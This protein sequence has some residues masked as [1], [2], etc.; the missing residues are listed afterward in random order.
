MD[1][2]LPE[3]IASLKRSP[4]LVIEA[5]P[6]A[7]KTTRVP[8][9][10]L[11]IVSG[12]V[13]VLEPRRIA[14]RLAARRVAWEIGEPVGQTIG[15]QVRFEEAVSSRTRVRFVTEGV[16]TR[17]LLSDR[18]LKGV[19]AVVLDE[20]HERHLESDLALALL[21]RL[22]QTRTDLRIIVM[23]A[24][25]DTSHVAEYLGGCPVLRSEGRLFEV[26]IRH[27]PYS[28]KSLEAQLTD[29]LELLI[30]E[31]PSG[32]VLAFLTGAAEIR[33]AMRE[34]QEVARRANL[35]VLPL[36]GDLSPAE[37][38]RAIMPAEQRKVIL[39][40]N[41]AESS[42]TVEGVNAV[43]D[44]G[45]ARIAT[46]SQ[47][48][49]LP[50]L[51]V[52]RVS[53]ASATQRAG[54]AGRTAPGRVLRL[55]GIEDYQRR[56]EHDAPEITRS[57]L[58]QL[59]LALRAMRI[60]DLAWLDAPPEA[61]W[62]IAEALLD[63]LG[64]SAER[65]LQLARYPLHPR[66]SRILI[67]AMERGVGED[68][69]V[70]A[71]LL[72]SGARAEKND[73]LTAID[74]DQDY[75]NQDYRT[76]QQV[77]LLRRIARPARQTEHNDDALLMSVLAGFPD[78]VAR[79]RAGNQVLLSTGGS[80]E[81][82]GDPPRY[83]FM[84]AV[85][86]EDRKDKPLPLIRMTAR[87]EPEWLIELFPDQV[88]E[89]SGVE[90]NRLGERVEAVSALLYDELVI[91]ESRGAAPDAEAAAGLLAQKALEAGIDRFVDREAVDEFVARVQF[92]GFE[93]PD[94]PQALK[95]L[96]QGL[97]SFN[98]LKNAATNLVSLLEQKMVARRL[99]QIAPERVR[100]PNGRQTKVHYE[101]GKP[102]W[103]ASRLQD[104][105]GMRETPRIGPGQT[106]VVVHLL[107]PNQRAVQTTSDLAGFWERLY[108]QVRRELMR[109]YPR[110]S[111]P[112]RP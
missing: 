108:P 39:A 87:I 55:Y 76:R 7:G 61:A 74:A 93:P 88:R 10:L 67:A 106:P 90:W 19:G 111:W 78:R 68:G 2:I 94:I 103:I 46:Y 100:L 62:E 51:H 95:D 14:A 17:R 21:K 18:T 59:C 96:C 54:R 1:A 110:H 71:A 28:A 38:D 91:Q 3:M 79:R 69:C 107:A 35:L 32:D 73:L 37:Q 104:F 4:N 22:Q 45:L 64:A 41:V 84:V 58:S 24:T 75:R 13:V 15:Y 44:S 81:V 63:R 31:E 57:D 30:A 80:A 42:V 47:W 99:E 83:E 109:R 65:V 27:L 29:A 34:S 5:P 33:R 20:F 52:G 77:E 89:K 6:G 82:A 9:A 102:P 112:E 16:L 66:L 26:S 43:I 48:T 56:P 23:S 12:E 49:G 85:D 40:T 101:T 36:H 92:A 53:K 70:A 97:R 50:T 8:P 105:F 86:A 72:G 25:L 11:E 60:N 98:E